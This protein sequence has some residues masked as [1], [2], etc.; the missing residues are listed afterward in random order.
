MVYLIPQK[1]AIL[2]NVNSPINYQENTLKKVLIFLLKHLDSNL[3]ILK[4]HVMV[5]IIIIKKLLK[6]MVFKL[7]AL[8][9]LFLINYFILII[10]L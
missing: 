3:N 4:L 9:Q 8:V 1:M 2:D 5:Y 10:V 7:L 6:V